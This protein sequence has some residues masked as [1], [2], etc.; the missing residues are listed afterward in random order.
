[1]V[2]DNNHITYNNPFEFSIR[3]DNN[4]VPIDIYGFDTDCDCCND[5]NNN[6]NI[7]TYDYDNYDEDNNHVDFFDVVILGINDLVA[8]DCYYPHYNYHNHK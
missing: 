7:I 6:I 2:Y 5:H 1:M 8:N 3:I 4:D